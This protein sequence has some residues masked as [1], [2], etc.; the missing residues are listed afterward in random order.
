MPYLPAKFRHELVRKSITLPTVLLPELVFKIAETEFELEASFRLVYDSYLKLG[1]CEENPFKLRATLHHALPTTTTLIAIHGHEVVGTLT[2]VRDN[3]HGLP[4]DKVFNLK[5]LRKESQ[6]VAEIT[7]LVIDEKYRRENGGQILFP[8][9]RLMYEY[10][11]SYF[12][13]K[14]IVVTIHPKDIHFYKSLLLF[15]DIPNTGVCIYLGAPAVALH[16]D[17]SKVPT[18]YKKTYSHRDPKSNLFYFFI[19]RKF[20]NIIFPKRQFNKINDPIV[21]IQYYQSTFVEKLGIKES[22]PFERRK[23]VST[24]LANEINRSHPRFE[25]ELKLKVCLENSE[26]I[27]DGTVKDVSPQGFRVYSD[28]QFSLNLKYNCII[29]IAPTVFSK[30]KARAIWKAPG[31]GIGFEI[32]EADASWRDFINYIHQD[33]VG[34]AS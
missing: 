12:G 32:L 27:F 25:A 24:I 22:N 28:L 23:V 15:K 4:I 11:T 19:K 13:V 33:H 14:H 31:A 29:E 18:E 10:A 17:L 30:L 34:K 1:Y 5:N 20:E 26:L 9:L 16:L 6:R 7:S 3:R 8:L 2:I 21:S